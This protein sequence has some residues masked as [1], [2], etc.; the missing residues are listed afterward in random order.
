MQ[1]TSAHVAVILLVPKTSHHRDSIFKE[2][3]ASS[4]A[5]DYALARLRECY[6]A[7]RVANFVAILNIVVVVT[8]QTVVFGVFGVWVFA[9]F[10]VFAGCVVCRMQGG[11]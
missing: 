8:S 9:V 11:R 6:C 3:K 1:R 5:A 2:Y 7:F 4:D 10:A